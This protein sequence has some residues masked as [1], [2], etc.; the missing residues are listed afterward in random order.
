MT[1]LDKVIAQLQAEASTPHGHD[2]QYR[3]SHTRQDGA[4]SARRRVRRPRPR[5]QSCL[6]RVR[7]R[8]HRDRLHR[9][10]QC[11][12]RRADPDRRVGVASD[13]QWPRMGA[14]VVLRS[15][16]QSDSDMFAG[17]TRTSRRAAEPSRSA[18]TRGTRDRVPAR[19]SRWRPASQQSV[20]PVR[21]CGR[22]SSTR[23][24]CAV[25]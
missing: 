3:G 13:R 12:R 7:H 21:R 23:V 1:P 10:L 11:H 9:R 25:S 8:S 14:R 15:G 4:D 6:S 17:H 20:G 19:R 2:G 16:R 22:P 24:L 5:R 18:C